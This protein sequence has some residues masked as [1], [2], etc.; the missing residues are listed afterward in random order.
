M[1]CVLTLLLCLCLPYPHHH[2]HFAFLLVFIFSHNITFPSH[3]SYVSFYVPHSSFNTFIL[4]PYIMFPL[5]PSPLFSFFLFSTT[6]S[7]TTPLALLLLP[8]TQRKVTA[9]CAV[10]TCDLA[11]QLFSVIVVSGLPPLCAITFVTSGFK[12]VALLRLESL[13]L[14]TRVQDRLL[15]V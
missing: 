9:L 15:K 6:I 13:L 11:L 7:S 2:F 4:I 3:H 1:F 8:G 5:Q 10:L 12:S 14:F